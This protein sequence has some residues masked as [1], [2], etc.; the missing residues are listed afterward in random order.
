M[1]EAPKWA[2]TPLKGYVGEPRTRKCCLGVPYGRGNLEKNAPRITLRAT[3]PIGNGPAKKKTSRRIHVQYTPKWNGKT[4]AIHLTRINFDPGQRAFS[5][6]F[7]TTW[8][9]IKDKIT[10][11]RGEKWA[12]PRV[13]TCVSYKE[14]WNGERRLLKSQDAPQNQQFTG[15]KRNP[16]ISNR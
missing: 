1:A 9:K 6:L 11:T 14:K 8:M 3:S 10:C 16:S 12:C 7:H 15:T 5:R 2:R 4:I 13:W